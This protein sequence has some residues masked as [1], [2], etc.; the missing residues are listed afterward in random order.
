M[1][2]DDGRTYNRAEFLGK[3]A[4][5]AVY[6]YCEVSTGKMFAAKFEPPNIPNKTLL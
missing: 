3:G 6:K 5:G 1:I 2:S 4:F